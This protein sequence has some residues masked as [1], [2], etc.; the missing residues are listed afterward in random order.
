M[1]KFPSHQ[2]FNYYNSYFNKNRN[3]LTYYCNIINIIFILFDRILKMLNF[4]FICCNIYLYLDKYVRKANLKFKYKI[5]N[6]L[7]KI[8]SDKYNYF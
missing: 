8:S 2:I 4:S 6:W 3:N 5:G 7:S 1:T